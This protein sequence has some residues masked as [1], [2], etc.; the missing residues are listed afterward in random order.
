M[1]EGI[2][3]KTANIDIHKEESIF[4]NDQIGVKFFYRK[5]AQARKNKRAPLSASCAIGERSEPC[6][7]YVWTE[8][9]F[10]E[11]EIE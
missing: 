1:L 4:V 8:I 7:L 3:L 6:N 11:G 5:P 2:F 9:D 10:P